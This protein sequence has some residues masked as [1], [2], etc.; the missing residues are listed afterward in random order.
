M[1]AD[2]SLAHW[3]IPGASPSISV[4]AVRKK[5]VMDTPGISTGYCMARNRPALAR[6]SGVILRMSLPSRRASP[7][8]TTYLGWP[9]NV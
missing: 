1:A 4:L 9:A 2:R 8:S 7:E 5:L 3:R 6:S